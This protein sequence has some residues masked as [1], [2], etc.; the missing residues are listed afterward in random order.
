MRSKNV[1][2]VGQGCKP[3]RR[4]VTLFES[5]R[6]RRC[7][8]HPNLYLLLCHGCGEWFH[9]RYPNPLTCSDRCRMKLSRMRH[10]TLFQTVMQFAD[11]VK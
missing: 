6:T 9:S 8:C 5:E 7:D 11:G 4:Q 10:E 2:P 1:V 3:L